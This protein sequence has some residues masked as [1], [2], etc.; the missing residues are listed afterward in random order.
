MSSSSRWPASAPTRST[1]RR[2]GSCSARCTPRWSRAP[3]HRP[4]CCSSTRPSTPPASAPTPTNALPTPVGAEVIDVDRGGKITFHG[5]GQL[6]G[7]PIVR[8]A[9]PRQGRRL[10][11]PGRGGADPGVCRPRRRHRPGARTQRRLAPRRRAGCGTRPERKIAAIGIRVSRGV[12][13]H[14]FSLNCDVDLGWYDRFVPCGIA[15]AGVTTLSQELG[16]PVT[17]TDVIPTVERHLRHYLDWTSYEP[18]PDYDP[19]P[20]S[21]GVSRGS[22]SSGRDP[23]R[24]WTREP[25]VSWSSR[26]P[27]SARSSARRRGGLRVAVAGPGPGGPRRRRARLP[28]TQRLRQDDDDPDAAR[29]GARQSRPDAALRP[30]GAAAPARRDRPGRRGG[31]DAEVL[32]QPQRHAATCSCSPAASVHRG[33]GW[34]PRSRSSGSP[35]AR[36]TASRATPSA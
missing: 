14:G 16:R 28:R 29:P 12:T 25:R 32:A 4:C 9:R 13:M 19:R 7:Y 35:V 31:G 30:G 21:P 2:P 6:V 18:T 33:P 8:P 10:R 34:T 15:D 24:P 5:P 1:T 23:L 17:V 26:P 27:D 36:G 11:A 22:S 3:V 20:G